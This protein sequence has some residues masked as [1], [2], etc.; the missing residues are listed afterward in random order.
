MKKRLLKRGVCLL[1]IICMVFTLAACSKKEEEKDELVMVWCSRDLN[2]E[3]GK[4]AQIILKHCAEEKNKNGGVNGAPVRV[5][6]IDGGTE[7]QAYLDALLLALDVEG[8][9]CIMGTAWS[10]FGIAAS[11]YIEEATIP[12][13]NQCTNEELAN[14]NEY[15]YLPRGTNFGM[16][17][18]W[19]QI[20]IDEGITK[21]AV[22]YMNSS[23]GFNQCGYIKDH[24]EKNGLEVVAEI[25]FDTTNTNDFTPHVLEA[26]NSGA[27]GVFI[28]SNGD[29]QG[30][31]ILTLLKEY[32]FPGVISGIAALMTPKFAALAG[33]EACNGVVGYSESDPYVDTP[34]N[35]EFL[36]TFYNENGKML[37]NTDLTIS[38]H[39]ANFYD[40]FQ[41]FCMAAEKEGANTPEA[42][43][44]GLKKID[45]YDGVMCN[46]CYNEDT[47]FANQMFIARYTGSETAEIEGTMPIDHSWRPKK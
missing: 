32:N 44:A 15:Y 10:Q 17:Y 41:M 23:S 9:D 13:F 22:I 42:I 30:V 27:D 18:S 39:D 20:G 12:V 31:A 16:T 46:Y 14:C 8:V 38:W 2:S 33:A 28:I 1:M 24:F 26:I 29:A 34:Q 19:A 43:N 37:E 3:I 35:Q 36:K 40:M 25:P 11:E 4:K 47:A 21:A 45:N 6:F 5:E 7:Q